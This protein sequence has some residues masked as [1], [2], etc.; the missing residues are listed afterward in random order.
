MMELIVKAPWGNRQKGDHI[1][2]PEEIDMVLKHHSAFV[3]KIGR[4]NWVGPVA[5]VPDEP[6]HL[7]EEGA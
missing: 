2:D 7:S 3:I 5:A 1:T 6:E 4:D